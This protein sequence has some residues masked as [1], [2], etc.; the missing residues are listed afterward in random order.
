[1]KILAFSDIHCDLAAAEALVAAARDADLVIGAG[2]FAQRHE[3]L[4]KIMPALAG[5]GDKALYI[6]GNNETVE[7]LRSATTA[8]VIHGAAVEIGGLRIAGLGCAVPPLP[9]MPWGSYDMPEAQ[10]A[11]ILEQIGKAD[12]LVS[13]SPPHKVVDVHADLGSIGST[14]VRDWILKHSPALVLCGHIHDCWGQEA[15]LG[16]TRVMNLGPGV[17]WVEI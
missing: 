5:I 3:G 9:P 1:M 12:I 7:A 15:K 16:E 10:A 4:D 17:T 11:E 13:H 14:A 2:D 8:R 6:P